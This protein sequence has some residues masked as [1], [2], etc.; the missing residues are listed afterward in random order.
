MSVTVLRKSVVSFRNPEG[1]V[2]DVS[3]ARRDGR[4]WMVSPAMGDGT[5]VIRLY[6]SS[7]PPGAPLDCPEW[8]FGGELAPAPPSDA[9][10]A[11]GYHCPSYVDGRI[12]Y[13]GSASWELAGPYSIGCVEWHAGSWRRR[14][15][16]VF[17]GAEPW[18]RGTVFEP[19]LV[20]ENGAWRI[21]YAAGLTNDD[22]QVIGT[23]A[24]PDGLSG[25]TD[26]R[27]AFQDDEFDAVVR[28]EGTVTAQHSLHRQINDT[29]GLWWNGDTQLVRTNDGTPWHAG[30]VWKPSVAFDSERPGH[31]SVFFNGAA[32]TSGPPDFT[33]GRIDCQLS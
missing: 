13:A 30:R 33:V 20:R 26:R 28:P 22:D 6:E 29:D 8:T 23:A 27:I 24:G 14:P 15:E 25:W 10:D 31:F 19:N 7:L 4:W 1:T 18:E 3:V 16:P 32:V 11:T 9:W 17:T 21:W 2:A 12:Y 5:R